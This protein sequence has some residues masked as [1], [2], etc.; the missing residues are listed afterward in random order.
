MTGNVSHIF[1]VAGTDFTA[2]DMT[3]RLAANHA[4]QLQPSATGASILNLVIQDTGEQMIKGSWD[5]SN[6]DIAADNGH[7]EGCLFQYTAGIGPQYYIGGM[8]VHRARNWVV[9]SNT[10]MYIRSPEEDLAEF[11]IHF[12][13]NAENTLVE[14]N[15][16]I[17]CDRGIG[18]GLGDRGHVGGIIRNNMIYH[19]GSEGRN[20]VGI[21]LDSTQDAQV[22][23]NTIYL[24]HDYPN[25]IEYRFAATTGVYIANNLTNRAITARD[26]ASGAEADNLTNAQDAWFRDL[27]AG[28]LHMAYA[29]P[30]LV[31]RA[32]AI[33]GLVDDHDGQARPQGAGYD[34]GADEYLVEQ[35]L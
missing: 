16:I 17:N 10:F 35:D 29:V 4:I 15:T 13:S 5:S 21:S 18:F 25:A 27:A 20:D 28:D 19:D 32:L 1:N 30:E 33:E 22:Y 7:V 9:R 11:A 24:A 3:L 14:R 6:P 23:N 2:R 8:D 34:I 26:D 31:D 12:W